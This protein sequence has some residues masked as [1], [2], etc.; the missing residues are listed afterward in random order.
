MK[1]TIL[2]YHKID[3]VRAGVR[4]PGNYV[5]PRNFERQLDALTMWGYRTISLDQWIDYRD[6]RLS[7]L[8]PR[9]LVLTFDDGYECFDRNAWPLMRARGMRGTVFVVAGQIGGYNAW[10][11]DELREPLLGA[12][13]IRAL[14][15]RGCISD[16]TASP[17]PRSRKSSRAAPST[18]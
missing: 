4:F 1:L 9:P 3:D 18:S 5:S 17:T 6:G 12:E 13:R 15:R 11:R 8:P 2:M 16:R 14:Q 10:D 7:S